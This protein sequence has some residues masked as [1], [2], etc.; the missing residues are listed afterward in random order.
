MKKTKPNQN[1]IKDWFVRNRK[2]LYWPLGGIAYLILTIILLL[3]GV[4][5]GSYIATYLFIPFMAINF[6]LEKLIGD[7]VLTPFLSFIIL[8]VLL[9][10]SGWLYSKTKNTFQRIIAIVLMIFILLSVIIVPFFYVQI[11]V[12]FKN[13]LK[14]EAEIL[15]EFAEEKISEIDMVGTTLTVTQTIVHSR[16]SKDLYYYIEKDKANTIS[17]HF[18][19]DNNLKLMT[20][21]YAPVQNPTT[22]RI[23]TKLEEGNYYIEIYGGNN[24]LN[25]KNVS[26]K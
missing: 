23:K 8:L 14:S 26:V 20:T 9:F 6:F 25:T 12:Y 11:K 22:I 18:F 21:G 19:M 3:V 4:S 15:D 13:D 1:K 10:I 7:L 24:L 16:S 2:I 17:V 5:F